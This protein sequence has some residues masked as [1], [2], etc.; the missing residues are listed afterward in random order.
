MKPS[1]QRRWIS[2]MLA[3]VVLFPF[4]ALADNQPA[5]SSEMIERILW[6]K[7]PIAVM[8]IVGQE[9]LVHF[10]DS[11]SV[12]IP[13]SLAPI[14]RSQSINGTLYLTAR[15][16]FEAN[17]VIVRSE[18]GEPIYV[19]D[20]SAKEAD[21]ESTR[22]PTLQILLVNPVSGE[23][24]SDGTAVSS[25]QW[26]Y[27]ALTR[28]AAQHL[29]APARLLPNAL[30]IVRM[31][32]TQQSF[33]LMLGGQ[34]EAIPVAAWKAGLHNITAVRLIN[35]TQHPVVL[36]PRQ[37]RGTWL[38]ATFQHNRLLPSGNDADSTAVYLV[39]DRPFDVSF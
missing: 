39:S 28:Y 29:Y 17:R 32:V 26:G 10:P 6:K 33:E 19:L 1:K 15:E 27:V 35:K 11:V 30:G 12:G 16:P 23:L 13:Q 14:L 21:P 20:I 4:M 25:A 36:D 22:L 24:A 31:P 9:R 18:Q 37:L 5:E 8:L 34:V 7:M 2:T 3:V 38:T